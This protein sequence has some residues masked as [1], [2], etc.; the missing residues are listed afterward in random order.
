M[1]LKLKEI[2]GDFY[3]PGFHIH[4]DYPEESIKEIERM[5][6]LGIKLIGELVPYHHK[7][8]NIYSSDLSEILKVAEKHNMVLSIHNTM[9]PELDEMVKNHKDM[10]F[11][12]AHP[13][14][15]S[16]VLSHIERMKKHENYYLDISG[17]G[18]FRYGMLR[19]VIDCCGADRILFGTD[20][21]TCHPSV[22]VGGVLYDNLLSDTEK[23]KIFSLNTKKLL[24]L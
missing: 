23:E 13:G 24:N 21:P 14:E 19:R 4:P 7:W 12:S 9:N 11:V 15:S 6:A 8:K 10:I 2:Y 17:T 20:Y 22:F 3:I 18:I 1:L 5:S 16:E